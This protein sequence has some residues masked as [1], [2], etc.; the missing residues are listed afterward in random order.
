MM[1]VVEA[2]R[3]GRQMVRWA[4]GYLV[5]VC[6]SWSLLALIDPAWYGGV[7]VGLFSL[8]VLTAVETCILLVLVLIPDFARKVYWPDS[9]LATILVI[10]WSAVTFIP[11]TVLVPAGWDVLVSRGP[12]IEHLRGV[13][14]LVAYFGWMILMRERTSGR[15]MMQ[16]DWSPPGRRGVMREGYSRVLRLLWA[17]RRSRRLWT[18]RRWWRTG[19]SKRR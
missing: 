17:R 2:Q 16:C 3:L 6:A 1:R 4:G 13:I 10:A 12:H 8:W 9:R 15:L 11:F 7:G 19:L 18:V 5:G 14:F